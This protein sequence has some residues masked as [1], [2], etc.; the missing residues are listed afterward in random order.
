[1]GF[2]SPSLFNDQRDIAE[3]AGAKNRLEGSRGLNE[4]LN[5]FEKVARWEEKGLINIDDL[6]Y[7]FEDPIRAYWFGWAPYVKALRVKNG[8]DQETGPTYQGFQRIALSL[9]KRP[10]VMPPTEAEI[11]NL[12]DYELKYATA[13]VDKR[14]EHHAP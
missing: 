10:K 4:V 6:D 3:A 7:Y 9:V 12:L 5:F 2:G 13:C 1:M 14:T 11:Q 8:E